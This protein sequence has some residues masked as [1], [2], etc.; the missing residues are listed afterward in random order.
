MTKIVLREVDKDNFKAII[1]LRVKKDQEQFVAPNV[2]SVAEAY[3]S[4][5]AWFR[6]IYA[7]DEPVGFVM[8]SLAPEK[9]EYFLWRFMIDAK[10]Q[11]SGLGSRSLKLVIDHIRSLPNA[12]A[13][14]TSHIEG[15][16]SPA[17]FY[18][19]LGFRYTDE[20]EDGELLMKLDLQHP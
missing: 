20:V 10:H 18:A 19:K 16:G 9:A 8:L 2:Q 5:E 4:D 6:A 14:Y 15:E 3:F 11:S 13:L 17:E 7:D 12:R 1:R